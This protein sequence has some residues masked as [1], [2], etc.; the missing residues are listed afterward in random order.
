MDMQI[1]K[2]VIVSAVDDNGNDL[3]VGELYA[4]DIEEGK[5]LVG[6]YSGITKRGSLAFESVLYDSPVTFN[7]MPKSIIR[8]SKVKVEVESM[9]KFEDGTIE[10]K[11]TVPSLM[12]DTNMI[13]REI[14]EAAIKDGL[15]EEDAIAFI[16]KSI[17]SAFMT[18]EQLKEKVA[19]NFLKLVFG[20]LGDE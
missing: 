19:K 9:I 20:K 6:S 7:V 14:K 12:T 2:E 18:K 15:S 11:G 16:R 13:L 17:E 3:V 1:K 5:C 10:L 8:I 4:F